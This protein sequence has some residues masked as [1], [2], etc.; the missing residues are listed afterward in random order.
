MNNQR[1]LGGVPHH[2]Y[3]QRAPATNQQQHNLFSNPMD[4][5]G[6]FMPGA[7]QPTAASSQNAYQTG[8]GSSL[9][10][11]HQASSFGRTDFTQ[12][13]DDRPAFA[14]Q[15][16]GHVQQDMQ[17]IPPLQRHLHDYTTNDYSSYI[18]GG[19]SFIQAATTQHNLTSSAVSMPQLGTTAA[20]QMAGLGTQASQLPSA[21]AFSQD[22]GA[23]VTAAPK[24][25]NVKELTKEAQKQAGKDKVG[26]SPK[27]TG[28]KAGDDKRGK[29]TFAC[30]FPGCLVVCPS[31]FAL[32]NHKRMHDDAVFRCTFEGCSA[33]FLTDEA[34]KQHMTKHGQGGPVYACQQKSCGQAFRT[35]EELLAH[36]ENCGM[37]A[38]K[39]PKNDCEAAF[40]TANALVEHLK[41]HTGERPFRCQEKGCW[42][43]FSKEIHL[44]AHQRT[45]TGDRPH[46]CTHPGCTESFKFRYALSKHQ[47]TAHKIR[48]W[49]GDKNTSGSEDSDTDGPVRSLPGLNASAEAANM[50]PIPKYY[51][52]IKTKARPP[53][54]LSGGNEGGD[55]NSFLAKLKLRQQQRQQEML[56]KQQRELERSQQ[57]AL[58][59]DKDR[60]EDEAN[61]FEGGDNNE[62]AGD[63]GLAAM[64]TEENEDGGNED[65]NM[66]QDDQSQPEAVPR[67]TPRT[68]AGR[69]RA[70]TSTGRPV[71]RPPKSAAI[72]GNVVGR[73]G[74][75]KRYECD[76]PGCRQSFTLH[77]SLTTHKKLHTSEASRLA[78]GTRH[79]KCTHSGCE[80]S[81]FSKR[82]LD[83]HL[84]THSEDDQVEED[85]SDG[86]A[87]GSSPPV[88][89]PDTTTTSNTNGPF[90]CSYEGCNMGFLKIKQLHEHQLTHEPDEGHPYRCT[91]AKC[92]AAFREEGEL[93]EHVRKFHTTGKRLRCTHEGCTQTFNRAENLEAHLRT[94]A[95]LKPY[96][97]QEDG[98]DV[99]FSTVTALRLH[100]KVHG[101]E[102]FRCRDPECKKEFSTPELLQAHVS[103]VH[104]T[105]KM[106]RCTHDGCGMSFTLA[107]QLKR[108][109]KKHDETAQWGDD[110]EKERMRYFVETMSVS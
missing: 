18:P 20:R 80:R 41:S 101:I 26:G 106:Y 45:H 32:S 61:S 49:K 92:G 69:K 21:A 46:K 72:Q 51:Q 99:S 81:F 68:R 36:M 42:A 54:T 35:P 12:T 2:Y 22:F 34:L 38:H 57:A 30:P 90:K 33:S 100:M 4:Y 107:W 11:S 78:E 14:Q 88:A 104:D 5:V 103:K 89:G 84:R 6:L 93:A 55:G 31:K 27:K 15:R 87:A 97:C 29:Q 77:A 52:P 7:T 37:R 60:T 110:A 102:T 65:E 47:Q 75:R 58:G 62:D 73:P 40:A 16:Y 63:D 8:Y 74:P 71:G 39:C 53:D 76:Y 23:A 9:S 67:N 70:A 17:S 56:E 19:A 79:H 98:C 94:H 3:Q 86:E 24:S 10:R 91:N 85:G 43:A 82:A 48:T 105:Q 13:Y 44:L 28:G 50:P 66:D 59:G 96:A 25:L 95:G 108:H 109:V 1:N 83:L 64:E